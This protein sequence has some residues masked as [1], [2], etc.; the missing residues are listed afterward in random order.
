[1]LN[2]PMR[3]QNRRSLEDGRKFYRLYRMIGPGLESE[4]VYFEFAD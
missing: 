2:K 4:W 3:N 1:M